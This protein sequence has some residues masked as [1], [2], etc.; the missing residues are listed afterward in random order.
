MVGVFSMERGS[1]HIQNQIGFCHTTVGFMLYLD[2]FQTVCFGFMREKVSRKKNDGLVL[3][4][5]RSMSPLITSNAQPSISHYERMV[6]PN[7]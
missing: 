1:P 7:K 2:C 6:I 5:V 3:E 4:N